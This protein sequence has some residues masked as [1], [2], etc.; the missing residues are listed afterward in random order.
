MRFE[1]PELMLKEIQSV[2]DVQL[3][4]PSTRTDSYMRGMANGMILID[5]IIRGIEPKYIEKPIIPNNNIEPGHGD[6]RFC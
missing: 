2:M 4:D 1:V 5:S 3:N 6:I